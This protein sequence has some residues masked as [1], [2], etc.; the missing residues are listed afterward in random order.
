MHA[1]CVFRLTCKRGVQ[2]NK[3]LQLN[4]FE[5]LFSWLC[6]RKLNKS[7]HMQYLWNSFSPN[8]T[9]LKEILFMYKLYKTGVPL[10]IFKKNL[11]YRNSFNYLDD[12]FGNSGN[13]SL[14]TEIALFQIYKKGF[15]SFQSWL[16]LH[17]TKFE[18][19]KKT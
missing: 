4:Y 6:H 9:Y 13:D 17:W 18:M 12:M 2:E 19:T 1:V 15:L 16:Y 8:K 7:I 3:R 10:C 5:N 14:S 11:S